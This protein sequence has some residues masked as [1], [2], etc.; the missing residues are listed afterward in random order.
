M[1]NAPVEETEL[2]LRYIIIHHGSVC[3]TAKSFLVVTALQ[4]A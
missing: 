1:I 3:L 2:Q 4:V